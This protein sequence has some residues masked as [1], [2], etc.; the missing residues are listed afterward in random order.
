MTELRKQQDEAV[1]GL[2]DDAI[3]ERIKRIQ[4]LVY[5]FIYMIISKLILIQDT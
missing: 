3:I 5:N 1:E 2:D 4:Y